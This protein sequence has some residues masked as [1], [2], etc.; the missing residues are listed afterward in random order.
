MC[1]C[2]L[3]GLLE[4]KGAQK[5]ADPEDRGEAMDIEDLETGPGVP[6]G[7]PPEA[8]PSPERFHMDLSECLGLFQEKSTS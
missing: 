3:Q 4:G 6:S 1:I 5:G 8:W 7:T 2:V